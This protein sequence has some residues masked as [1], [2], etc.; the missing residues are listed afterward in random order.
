MAQESRVAWSSELMAAAENLAIAG[1][2]YV[3]TTEARTH[4]ATHGSTT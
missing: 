1:E 2:D 4:C 3:S